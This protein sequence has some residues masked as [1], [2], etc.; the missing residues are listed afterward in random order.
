MSNNAYYSILFQADPFNMSDMLYKYAGIVTCKNQ[1][2]I[3]PITSL[4]IIKNHIIVD[5]KVYVK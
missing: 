3:S 2:H 1:I 5:L 4:V